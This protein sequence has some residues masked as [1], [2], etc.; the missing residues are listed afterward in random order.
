[1]SQRRE[2]TCAADGLHRGIDQAKVAA[3]IRIAEEKLDLFRRLKN[4]ATTLATS[5]QD[6][7]AD[8]DTVES[9]IRSVLSGVLDEMS[10]EETVEE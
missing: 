3:A 9:E 4:N 6:L 7:R 2:A 1:M 5:A 8:L 10:V